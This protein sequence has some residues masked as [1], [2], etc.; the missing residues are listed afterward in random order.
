MFCVQFTNA[1][2]VSNQLT[3]T[4]S[5]S[6]EAS[7]QQE[8]ISISGR[9]VDEDG[10]PVIGANV[11][12][13]GISNGTV[14]D[15]DG[16]FSLTVRLNATISVSF[17]GYRDQEI[18]VGN[19]TT[20]KITLEEDTQA[21]DELIV[22]G[23]GSVRKKDLTGSVSSIASRDIEMAP[24]AS[25]LSGMLQG[26]SAGV[27]VMIGSASPTSPVSVVIRGMSSLSGDGQPLWIIDGVPQYSSGMSGDVS[28][29]LYK[30]NL[31]DVQS[32]DILKDASATAIYGSRA[33]NGVVMVT[34]KTGLEGMK[35]TIELSSRFGFQIM[36]SNDF[37]SMNKDQYHAF[38]K[39]AN[40][41]EAFRQGSPTYFNRKY[42][43]SNKFNQLNTSQWDMSDIDDMWLENAYYDGNDNYWEIGRAHV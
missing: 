21:L 38:S 8:K 2:E 40:L 25:S 36:D 41:L 23:Y 31:N 18:K 9:V 16:N 12:E 26:K 39:Q 14:T 37:E 24:M 27:N 10:I 6:K 7:L 5:S 28:N 29:V 1:S 4:L 3:P 43:D 30:L 11:L 20:F 32:V 42:M 34:T 19:K 15:I 17:I 13:K 22:M 33:A 35:P